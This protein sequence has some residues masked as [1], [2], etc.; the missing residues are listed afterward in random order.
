VKKSL[1]NAGLNVVVA[2]FALS[3]GIRATAAGQPRTNSRQLPAVSYDIRTTATPLSGAGIVMAGGGGAQHFL[4]HAVY[5]TGRSRVDIVE[6]GMEPLFAKGDYLLLDSAGLTVVHPAAKEYVPLSLDPAV[7]SSDQLKAL[8][9]AMTMGDLKVVMDSLPGTDT[10]AGYATRHFR[11]TLAFTMSI[12]AAFMQ[13]RMAT[14]T[15]TDYWIADVPGL[16]GNPLLR[17]NGLSAFSAVMAPFKELSAKVDSAAARLGN[18]S[19]LRSK[20]VSR[21]IQGPGANMTSE[22]SSEV[23][24]IQRTTV[25]EA[26]LAVPTGYRKASIG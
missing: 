23:S 9:V 22:Q 26:T 4:G 3:A 8:G 21:M 6:G 19:A 15:V 12:D 5:S 25:D 17:A 18:A 13:Q 2:V 14:E 16:P 20:T 7:Q 10:I 11:M 24:N 1:V